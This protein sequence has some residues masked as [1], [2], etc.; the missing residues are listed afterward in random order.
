MGLRRGFKS[1]ADQ[2]AREIRSELGLAPAACLDP[3]HLARHLEIPIVGLS[4]VAD[5]APNAARQFG[6]VDTAAFSA[7]TVFRGHVREIVHNDF[8]LPGRQASNVA[9]ELS[10]G[11]LL[12]PPAPALNDLGLRDWDAAL[13]EEA[14]WLAGALLIPVEAAMFIARQGWSDELAAEKYKVSQRMVLFR[15]N[16]TAARRRVQRERHNR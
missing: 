11:L 12:H 8:H 4:E 2:I 15:M 1:E 5:T 9:H 14:N 7:V 6:I 3:W 16:V 10:H 13:E